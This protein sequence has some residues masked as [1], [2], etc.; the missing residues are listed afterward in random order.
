MPSFLSDAQRQILL[1]KARARHA[2][3]KAA[4]ETTEAEIRAW[5]QLEIPLTPPKGK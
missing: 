1:A 2:R 5:E 4:L 3:Q